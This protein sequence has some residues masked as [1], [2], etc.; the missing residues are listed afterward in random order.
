MYSFADYF[1]VAD[2]VIMM[3][4]YLP[5]YSTFFLGFSTTLLLKLDQ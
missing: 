1:D 4:S 2:T 3:Q 5:Q